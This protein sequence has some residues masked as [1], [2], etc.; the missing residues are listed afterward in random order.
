LGKLGVEPSGSCGLAQLPNVS[1]ALRYCHA[2][3]NQCE[4]AFTRHARF[5]AYSDCQILGPPHRASLALHVQCGEGCSSPP[6]SRGNVIGKVIQTLVL[7]ITISCWNCLLSC[8][9]RVCYVLRQNDCNPVT[10][11]YAILSMSLAGFVFRLN[12]CRTCS[13]SLEQSLHSVTV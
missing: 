4:F 11:P 5:A 3:S 9:D 8:L 13:K 7:V 1:W 10:F 12:V 6:P 2:G